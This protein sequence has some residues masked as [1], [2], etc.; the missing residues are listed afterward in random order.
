MSYL[1]DFLQP[2]HL[3]GLKN[4]FLKLSF[5]TVNDLIKVRQA[6]TASIRKHK[7]NEDNAFY[8]ELLKSAQCGKIHSETTKKTDQMENIIEIR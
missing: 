7:H 1:F 5:A 6:I 4:H 3:I 8:T 2:N